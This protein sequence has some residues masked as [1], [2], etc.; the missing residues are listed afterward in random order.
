MK[1]NIVLI[2]FTTDTEKR[3]AGE[4]LWVDPRSAKHFVE[5]EKVAKFVGDAEEKAAAKEAVK[6]V[7][8]PDKG[9]K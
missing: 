1:R 8:E 6:A 7:P 2:E 4:Q 3:S 9:D 5:R